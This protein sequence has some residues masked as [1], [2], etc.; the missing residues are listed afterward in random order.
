MADAPIEIDLS[1]LHFFKYFVFAYKSRACFAGCFGL[2]GVGGRYDANSKIGFD[3]MRETE[4]VA[5]YGAVFRGFEA[6]MEFVFGGRGCAADFCGAEVA[7]REVSVGREE[8]GIWK[9]AGK[10]HRIASTKGNWMAFF[11]SGVSNVD[12]AFFRFR[13]A[14]RSLRLYFAALADWTAVRTWVCCRTGRRKEGRIG[15]VGRI[16]ERAAAAREMEERQ[17]GQ[18]LE[19]DAIGVD[20]MSQ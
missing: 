5:D 3:G 17:L 11:R 15:C 12:F 14:G 18:D 10:A 9:K 4:T 19:A 7:G 8:V 20:S 13:D 1:V 6:H 16:W 2:R